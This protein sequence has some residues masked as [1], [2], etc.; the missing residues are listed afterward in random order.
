MASLP[1]LHASMPAASSTQMAQ[2]NMP[3]GML[4]SVDSS[5]VLPTQ[6]PPSLHDSSGSSAAA[7]G[8]QL[9]AGGAAPK[10]GGRRP[11]QLGKAVFGQTQHQQQRVSMPHAPEQSSSSVPLHH[12]SERPA[13]GRQGEPSALAPGLASTSKGAAYARS[14]SESGP[15]ASGQVQDFMLA[16]GASLR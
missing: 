14:A 13:G 5:V 4:R 10:E 1:T 3:E 7:A 15:H 9:R 2:E 8:Q 11:E 12:A 16:S 6:A